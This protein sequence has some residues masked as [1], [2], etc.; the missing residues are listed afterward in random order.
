MDDTTVPQT[1]RTRADLVALSSWRVDVVYAGADRDIPHHFHIQ[2]VF[3]ANAW[4][5]VPGLL[6]GYPLRTLTITAE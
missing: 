3:F 1:A 2:A 6:L 4:A 5:Q